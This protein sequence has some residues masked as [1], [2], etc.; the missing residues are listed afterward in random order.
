MSTQTKS[1][2]AVKAAVAAPAVVVT[3]KVVVLPNAIVEQIINLNNAKEMIK[4][5]EA[6]KEAADTAI[7]AALGDAT[8]GIVNGEERIKLSPR[9]NTYINQNILKESFPEAF[10]AASYKTPFTVLV[11]K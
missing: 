11:T 6:Q 4:K 5:F 3:P 7:R 1:A 8:V 2:K 10:E 9:E